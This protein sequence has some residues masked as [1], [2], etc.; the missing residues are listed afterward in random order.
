MKC[1][2]PD[3]WKN[4]IVKTLPYRDEAGEI[5]PDNPPMNAKGLWDKPKT[6]ADYVKEDKYLKKTDS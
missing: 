3:R 1:R 6:T 5:V 4:K 2:I